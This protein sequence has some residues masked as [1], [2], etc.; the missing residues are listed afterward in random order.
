LVDL[1]VAE[2]RRLLKTTHSR[3]ARAGRRP[4]GSDTDAAQA[5]ATAY[6]AAKDDV[7]PH[8]DAARRAG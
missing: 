2:V 8:K 6:D 3:A 1:E 7:A 5:R 4:T